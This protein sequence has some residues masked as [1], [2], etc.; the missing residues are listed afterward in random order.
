M[1]TLGVLPT[2]CRA[3]IISKDMEVVDSTG[4]TSK[5]YVVGIATTSVGE[6]KKIKQT[7]NRQS[8]PKDTETAGEE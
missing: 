4:N 7:S 2:V 3:D 6:K 5:N 8:G 1:G